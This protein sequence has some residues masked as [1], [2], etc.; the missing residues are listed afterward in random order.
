MAGVDGVVDHPHR[1]FPEGLRTVSHVGVAGEHAIMC[2]TVL[3]PGVTFRETVKQHRMKPVAGGGKSCLGSFLFFK[4]VPQCAEFDALI[5]RQEAENA[6][7]RLCFAFMLVSHV[8]GV[9][10]KRVPGVDFNEI[11]DQNHLEDTQDV[12]RLVVRMLGEHN[13]H[14]REMPRVL[15]AV[16]GA[17]AL[18]DERLA[19]NLLQLVD[20]RDEPD[21]AAETF[22]GRQRGVSAHEKTEN[23]GAGKCNPGGA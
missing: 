21:L 9:V 15:R 18:S 6:R 5:G 12:E 17:P 14:E 16:L 10:R 19:E 8:F 20:L 7:G 11:V 13:D 4:L 22:S 2:Y 3:L 1:I 23:T